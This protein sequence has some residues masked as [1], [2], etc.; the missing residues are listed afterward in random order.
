MKIRTQHRPDLARLAELIAAIDVVMLATNSRGGELE[1]RPMTPIEMDEAGALWFFTRRHSPVFDGTGP[2]NLAFVDHDRSIYVSICGSAAQV[3]DRE[4][5]RELWTPM[6]RPWFP[7]GP[8]SPDLSL[9]RVLPTTADIWDAPHSKM[10]RVLAMAA[11][12]A[13]GQPVG[14]GGHEHLEPQM[15]GGPLRPAGA[16]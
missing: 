7:E 13:A 8:D 15:P 10:V 6:A 14:L 11:S 9:L 4:R 2:V 5:L 12:V 16:T 1:N 3:D